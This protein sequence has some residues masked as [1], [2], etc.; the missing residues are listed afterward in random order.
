MIANLDARIDLLIIKKAEKYQIEENLLRA[1]VL[2]E[3]GGNPYAMRAE[4][5]YPWLYKVIQLSKEL[6]CTGPTMRQMQSTSWGLM[7]IMGAVAYELGFKGWGSEL[8]NPEINLEY[9]CRFLKQ[10]IVKYG[11][12]VFDIY[13]AYNAGSV[14]MM[15]KD[16]YKNQANVTQFRN[17]YEMLVN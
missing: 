8:C 9:G 10:K 7:Q 4:P 15:T 5:S 14:R 11:P 13:A 17:I 3:S 6:K 12:N 16:Q 1:I 2:L